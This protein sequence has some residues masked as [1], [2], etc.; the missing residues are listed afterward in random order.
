NLN[1]EL[2][3]NI[4]LIADEKRIP[5]DNVSDALKDAITKAYVREYPETVVEVIIDIEEKKLEVNKLLKV[6][7]P[8]DDFNDYCEILLEDAL[9]L[10][11]Q[12]KVGDDIKEPID[13]TLLDRAVIAHILQIFKSNI[14]IQTNAQV[15]KD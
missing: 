12:A 15:F 1:V 10:D 2:I 8:Y 13:L 4:K 11:P 6:V 9:K 7:E 5:R 14:T 3:N